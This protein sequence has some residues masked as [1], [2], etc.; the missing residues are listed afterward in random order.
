MKQ[1]SLSLDAPNFTLGFPK[2]FRQNWVY[3][4][5]NGDLHWQLFDETF[6]LAA[7][8]LTL[9][10]KVESLRG[11]LH[12]DIPLNKDPLTMGLTVGINGA[13]AASIY[14]YIPTGLPMNKGLETWLDNAI[15]QADI[16]HGGFLWNGTLKKTD[17]PYDS[18]WGLYLD[19]ENGN[20]QYAPGWPNITALSGEIIVNNDS[21][22]V[23][24]AHAETMGGTLENT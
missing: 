1:G 4:Q 13:T 19:I 11:K 6:K 5:A 14:Q 15:Q 8:N 24:A 18:R 22:Y 23:N 12:L 2:L 16:A 20:I 21:V 3:E 17:N 10:S 9:D 7:N